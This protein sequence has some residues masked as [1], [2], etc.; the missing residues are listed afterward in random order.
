[1]ITLSS[2]ESR[3]RQIG[4]DAEGSDRYD[5]DIDVIPAVNAAQQWL[6]SVLS[7]G[8]G[9]DKFVEERLTDLHLTRVWQT[10][11]LSR[12]NVDNDCGHEIWTITRVAPKPMVYMPPFNNPL[13]PLTYK[14]EITPYFGT[15]N[16]N[17]PLVKY[18][19]KTGDL[20]KPFQSTFRPELSHVSASHYATRLP[21][22]R[23]VGKNPFEAGYKVADDFMTYG[24]LSSLDYT[25]YNPLG[26]YSGG[27]TVVK[28]G[29]VEI[30]PYGRM[31]VSVSFLRVPPD[32]TT[33]VSDTYELPWPGSMMEVLTMKALNYISMKQGD[34]TTIYNVSL[35]DVLQQ[36]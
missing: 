12:F 30:I 31:L 14:M 17:S 3:I 26:L 1:M 22:E 9:K 7:Q 2:I 33:D 10:S 27:Y 19:Y 28:S 16:I 20:L 8:I 24:Y 4:L 35:Q 15:E 32:I 13:T 6:T 36:L 21:V 34:N 29:E 11:N 18:H 23:E 25:T 5:R